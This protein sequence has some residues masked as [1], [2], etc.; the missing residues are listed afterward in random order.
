MKTLLAIVLGL[1][2]TGTALAADPLTSGGGDNYSSLI[3]LLIFVFIFYFLLIRPQMKRSK[4][5]REMLGNL[6]VGDEVM[7]QGGL[8]GKIAKMEDSFI[9]L[10][11]ADSVTLKY[12]KQ[13]ITAV[14][15]KGT[16]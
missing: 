15:P 3:F 7:T 11:V 10:K 4:Q 14:L 1:G 6:S 16:A 8:I 12:Q 9:H 2:L 13:A 5:T